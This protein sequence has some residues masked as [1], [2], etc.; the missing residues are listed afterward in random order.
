M[1]I[2]Q[3][4]IMSFVTYASVLISAFSFV[5]FVSLYIFRAEFYA[6]TEIEPATLGE[7]YPVSTNALSIIRFEQRSLGH[8][9]LVLSNYGTCKN[10]HLFVNDKPVKRISGPSLEI[11]LTQGRRQYKLIPDDCTVLEP[12]TKMIELDIHFGALG[13]PSAIIQDL[14]REQVQINSAN[15]PVLMEPSAGFERWVPNVNTWRKEEKL[16]A[17]KLLND[18]GFDADASTRDKI[19]F[20]SSFVKRNMPSGSPPAYL[21][22][23][24]PWSV[25]RDA[26]EKGVGCFCRQWSLVYGYLANVVGIPTRNLFTGG[27][28]GDVDMGSHAF[29]ESYI[30]EEARWAYV[31]P[32]NDIAY[33]TDQ[34]GNVLTGADVYMASVT[35][36]DGTLLARHLDGRNGKFIPFDTVNEPVRYFMHRENF[37]IYIGAYDGRYQ[38]DRLGLTR[39]PFKLWRFLFQPQ[40]YYGY[41]PFVSFHWL[42]PVSFFIALLSGAFFL[43]VTFIKLIRRAQ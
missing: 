13:T 2:R 42:R 11:P 12:A 8:I 39:Y 9:T 28:M 25:F 18:E 29:S 10:W 32:T 16:S 38:M 20:L 27:A 1:T 4:R 31:D 17:L 33:V 21:N 30:A 26:S 5:F 23:I 37:L 34:S 36:M 3:C 6:Q 41:T 40:Q 14:S 19:Y 24:T 15:I 22:T 43:G 7:L 35:Q